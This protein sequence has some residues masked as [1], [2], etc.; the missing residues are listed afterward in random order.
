MLRYPFGA[1]DASET[2]WIDDLFAPEGAQQP[3][4][5]AGQKRAREK[6]TPPCSPLRPFR[7]AQQSVPELNDMS[8]QIA[9]IRAQAPFS[10]PAAAVAAPQMP[11]MP[12]NPQM[13]NPQ[14]AIPVQ[15]P[16]P[17]VPAVP[18]GVPQGAPWPSAGAASAHATMAMTAMKPS[19]PGMLAPAPALNQ[20]HWP[21]QQL[22]VSAGRDD[23]AEKKQLHNLINRRRTSRI[24]HL[25]S[26]RRPA[27]LHAILPDRSAP[28]PRHTCTPPAFLCAG[29]LD[30]RIPA[31]PGRARDDFGE[32]GVKRSKAEL[33]EG[34]HR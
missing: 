5:S 32:Q 18:A 20:P 25:L 28:S 10:L 4:P 12:E 24:N 33:L 23:A 6:E 19:W 22:M 29:E 9:M 1:T 16:N 27:P 3:P 11:N 2:T 26:A 30:R 15:M 31:V 13:S 7:V 21:A 34:A 8:A 14:N 17:H